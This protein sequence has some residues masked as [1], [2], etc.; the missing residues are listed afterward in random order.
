MVGGLSKGIWG[1]VLNKY[2]IDRCIFP[3]KFYHME[4][5]CI[6]QYQEV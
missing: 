1:Y 4:K 6:I 2:S 5:Q 3:Q